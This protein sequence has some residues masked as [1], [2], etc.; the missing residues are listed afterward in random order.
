[1]FNKKDFNLKWNTANLYT[2][3]KSMSYKYVSNYI[4]NVVAKIKLD[5][6]RKYC[7]ET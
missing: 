1:M 4:K 2:K 7:T 5:Y 6:G 3:K